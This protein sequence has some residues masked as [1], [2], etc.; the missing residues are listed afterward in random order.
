MSKPNDFMGLMYGTF[1]YLCQLLTLVHVID[2][3][4]SLFVYL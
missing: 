1:D 2:L 3:Q 4:H